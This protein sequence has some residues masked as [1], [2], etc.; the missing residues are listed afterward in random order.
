MLFDGALLLGGLLLLAL[1]VLSGVR[2]IP[3]DRVGIVEKGW[4]LRGSVKG[5]L[6]WLKEVIGSLVLANKCSDAV[7][8][9]LHVLDVSHLALVNRERAEFARVKGGDFRR[10]GFN[11]VAEVF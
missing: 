11:D 7:L 8:D 2:Y 3:N 1:I 4:S 9:D 5:G 6:A 10:Q